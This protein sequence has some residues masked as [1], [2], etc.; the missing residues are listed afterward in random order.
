MIINDGIRIDGRDSK[1]V[2]NI[3]IQTGDKLKRLHGWSVFTRGET[4][5]L[6]VSTLASEKMARYTDDLCPQDRE[7][8]MLHYSFPPYSVGEVGYQGAPKR[9]EI[10]HGYLARKAIEPV[11]P[12]REEFP[13]TI[14]V[15]STITGSNG[16]SSMA[17]V[18]GSSIALMDAGVPIKAAVAGVAMGMIV[19]NDKSVVL[20]DILGDEDA[21]GSMDFKVAGTAAGVTALQMDLKIKGINWDIVKSALEQA[22]VA[23][24]HVLGEMNKVI[25]KPRSSISKYAP[26]TECFEIKPDKIR[27]V[28]GKGGAT[29]KEITDRFGV[30]IDIEDS[31]LIKV[32]AADGQMLNAAIEHIKQIVADV[33]IDQI[34]NAKIIKMMDFGAVVE[35]MP[36]KDGFLHISQIANERVENIKDHLSMD[37]EIKVKVIEIDR[38][39]RVKVSMR[40]LI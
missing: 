23:R 1:T 21:L 18:A 8:F 4:Q 15:N 16:S 7:Y 2:R 39:G 35:L 32:S 9:R 25:D 12:S 30:E 31:G 34:Y 17:T 38:S 33:E 11:L 19:K 27:E 14:R 3:D 22:K 13:Y 28:I 26:R 6:V 36:G 37:Q 40:A 24:E 10:G 20:T 5:A 29:I